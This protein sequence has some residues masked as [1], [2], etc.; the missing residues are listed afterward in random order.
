MVYTSRYTS[1]GVDRE[2]WGDLC[3]LRLEASFKALL[4]EHPF[5]PCAPKTSVDARDEEFEFESGTVELVS[6]V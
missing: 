6:E 2:A 3:V 4:G 5:T 1:C